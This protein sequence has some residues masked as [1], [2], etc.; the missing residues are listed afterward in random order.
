[1]AMKM[2]NFKMDEADIADMKTV[3]NVYNISVTDLI[4]GA[5]KEYI[6]EL[7]QDPFYR[8]TVNVEDASPEESNEILTAVSE[9]SDDD[10]S[11][12]SVKRFA[13]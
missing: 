11:I 10:L 2:M 12:S 7:K 6:A 3:A 5:L 4:R 9:L 13:I 1:M 8:L